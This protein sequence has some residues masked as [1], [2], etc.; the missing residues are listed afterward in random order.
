MSDTRNRDSPLAQHPLSKRVAAA[1]AYNDECGPGPV[2]R[3]EYLADA[4]VLIDL[5]LPLLREAQEM[6]Y[7][8]AD[9]RQRLEDAIG[10]VP[11]A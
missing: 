10:P 5:I 6:G 3:E 11:R 7:G 9:Y 8:S 2:S 1:L 4:D